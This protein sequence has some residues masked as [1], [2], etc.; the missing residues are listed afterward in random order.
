MLLTSS[1]IRRPARLNIEYQERHTVSV[2]ETTLEKF[3]NNKNGVI[4]RSINIPSASND[5][6]R[7]AVPASAAHSMANMVFQSHPARSISVAKPR[8]ANVILEIATTAEAEKN[9]APQ[10]VSFNVFPTNNNNITLETMPILAAGPETRVSTVAKQEHKQTE[11]QIQNK[12]QE[13]QQIERQRQIQKKMQ[14]Q[15]QIER[16]IQKKKQEQEQLMRQ[17]YHNELT[18]PRTPTIKDSNNGVILLAMI[19]EP[20]PDNIVNSVPL[21][22][23][24]EPWKPS[25]LK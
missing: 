21:P 9:A 6:R 11:R 13:Q 8:V 17:M 16:Q 12:K 4:M 1:S 25:W 3:A 5:A 24:T 7:Q 15:E 2:N 20:S 19:D 22:V 18:P 10:P 14:E 23:S